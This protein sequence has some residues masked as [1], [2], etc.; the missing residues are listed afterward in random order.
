MTIRKYLGIGALCV[1]AFATTLLAAPWEAQ[2]SVVN[3]WYRDLAGSAPTA[4]D[5]TNNYVAVGDIIV[6]S[7]TGNMYTILDKV[8]PKYVKATSTGA[9]TFSYPVSFADISNKVG[10][11]SGT[12]F[13]LR[14]ITPAIVNKDTTNYY[15]WIAP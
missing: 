1:I 15:M 9:I 11:I 14:G 6:D 10:V 2:K 7:S 5:I 13:I 8:T 12:N 3:R 4:A